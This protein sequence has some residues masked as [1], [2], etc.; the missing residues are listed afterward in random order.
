MTKKQVLEVTRLRCSWCRDKG[1]PIHGSGRDRAGGW[2]A[3]WLHKIGQ[4]FALCREQLGWY[5]VK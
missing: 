2:A 1:A 5:E 4:R 3:G